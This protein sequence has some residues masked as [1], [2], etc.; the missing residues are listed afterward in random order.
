[1][2]PIVYELA[3]VIVGLVGFVVWQSVT[4]RRDM[5]ITQ[6]R[7]AEA[8]ARDAQAGRGTDTDA[9]RDPRPPQP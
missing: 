1:M 5:R 2:S 8:A 4:L 7:K 9:Q 6:Q 3:L